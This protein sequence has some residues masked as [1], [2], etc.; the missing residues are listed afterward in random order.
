MEHSP[1]RYSATS[2][3]TP[4]MLVDNYRRLSHITYDRVIYSFLLAASSLPLFHYYFAT[5][6]FDFIDDFAYSEPRQ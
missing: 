4:S 3:A 6:H 5:G 2:T 1:Q